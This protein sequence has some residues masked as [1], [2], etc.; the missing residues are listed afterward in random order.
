MYTIT[1]SLGFTLKF[2]ESE[3]T[4]EPPQIH[5]DL[6]KPILN[7]FS[8]FVIWVYSAQDKDWMSKEWF[9]VGLS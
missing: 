9:S 8:E 2:N 7:G 5:R 3:P 4:L 1:V 6:C